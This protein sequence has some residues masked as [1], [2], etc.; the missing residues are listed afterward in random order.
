MIWAAYGKEQ[1]GHIAQFTRKPNGSVLKYTDMDFSSDDE[2]VT[3][4][5]YL[6]DS[7]VEKMR[8]EEFK[9]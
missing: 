8:S 3:M 9:E 2:N 5:N 7:V 6:W 4:K 1:F